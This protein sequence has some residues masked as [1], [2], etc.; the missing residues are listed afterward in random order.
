MLN[1]K[2][3]ILKKTKKSN[4]FI[5]KLYDILTNSLYQKIISWNNDG[6]AI[7]IKDTFKLCEIVLP[8]FFK[9]NNFSSFVRQLNLYGFH[10]SKGM[11]KEGELFEHD[12]L[13]KESTNEQIEEIM[14]KYKKNKITLK[15]IKNDNNNDEERI[16]INNGDNNYSQIFNN[17]G[18]ILKYLIEKNEENIK[19]IIELRKEIVDL[20]TENK[21]LMDKLEMFNHNFN[22][23]NIF[24]EK[25]LKRKDE[26]KLNSSTKKAKNIKELFNKYLYYLRIYS[27]YLSINKNNN[28]SNTIQKTESFKIININENNKKDI[29]NLN[30]NFN[31]IQAINTNSNN[32]LNGLPFFNQR[33]DM[34]NLVFNLM[35]NNSYSNSFFYGGKNINNFIEINDNFFSKI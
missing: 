12:E 16:D 29:F 4:S 20:K 21:K 18:D 25:L 14:N 31:N 17:E 32:F 35:N 26:N 22:G 23:H 7:L 15:F 34:Q 9:H 8:I 3:N 10:K 27:P 33:Q 2:R 13:N 30:N 24:I 5:F 19:S 28:S 11:T 6:T 1:K